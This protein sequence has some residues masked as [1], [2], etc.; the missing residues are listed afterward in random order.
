M[1]PLS[2]HGFTFTAHN[3]D[4][5]AFHSTLANNR[6]HAVLSPTIAN[7]TFIQRVSFYIVHSIQ[8]LDATQHNINFDYRRITYIHVLTVSK[9]A[10][11]ESSRTSKHQYHP[12]SRHS[13]NV[14]HTHTM[15]PFRR[16]LDMGMHSPLHQEI[17][18]R[19]YD[20][21]TQSIGSISRRTRSRT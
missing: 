9:I 2:H 14:S 12:F 5:M 4:R 19:L 13:S 3:V 20:Q 10:R 15:R 8:T 16:A 11:R 1:S 18:D 21:H 7:N 17:T 6:T